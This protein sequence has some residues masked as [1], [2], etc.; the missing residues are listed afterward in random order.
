M[1][2]GYLLLLAGFLFHSYLY[3]QQPL[4][5]AW[6]KSH[7]LLVYRI[8]ADTAEKYVRSGIK[9]IDHYLE[10]TPAMIFPADTVDYD[11]IP[12]GNYLL[13]AVKDSMVEAEYYCSTEVLPFISNDQV[14]PQLLLRND[15]GVAFT[16]AQVWINK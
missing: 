6:R 13:I 14:Q 2:K 9:Q 8:S 5:D 16:N 7:Q 4:K 1:K 15:K 12:V 10:Q 11:A 3:A